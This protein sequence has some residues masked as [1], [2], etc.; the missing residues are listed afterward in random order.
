MSALLELDDVNVFYGPFHALRGNSLTVGEG[1]IVSLLGGNASGKSTTMKTILG[2]IRVK[3]GTVRFAG[4]DIT[5]SST[6]RRIASGIASVPEARRV[7]PQMTVDENLLA[8]A[9]TRSDRAG[10]ADD[11]ERMREH[12]P[13]LAERRKQEAGTLS[14][15]EQQM[16]AFARALM[17]RPKLICMDEPTMGLSPKLV[18]Q[19]L[20]E[21]VRINTELGVAVLFVEQ[22]AELAL[23]I[24]S[25]GYVL[26]TGAIVLEGTAREL[27]DDPHIQEAYLGKA[28]S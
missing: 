1:E 15:G 23:S 9:Y 4:A 17:S 8:G 18:D 3:S 25:R 14:G 20:D 13:R 28:A 2:L 22:Q 5:H 19:V 21:I 16:L 12:F 10:I 27:L 6:R 11:L 7:F 24:A 26:A